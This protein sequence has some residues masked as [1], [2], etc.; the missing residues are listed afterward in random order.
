MSH[1]YKWDGTDDIASVF[2]YSHQLG[3]RD[4]SQTP[5][6]LLQLTFDE[7]QNLI[8]IQ[9]AYHPSMNLTGDEMISSHEKQQEELQ[10]FQTHL[11]QKIDSFLH[12]LPSSCSSHEQKWFVKTNRHSCKDSPLDHPTEK[13]LLIYSHELD[14]YP[15]PPQRNLDEIDFGSAF[16]AMC[17]S[18]LIS[19]AIQNGTD[20]I[21]LLLRSKRI[22]D[23]FTLQIRLCPSPWD[24]YL[25]FT[26]F[27]DHMAQYPLHE[28]RCYI[29]NR[30]LRCIM[31]YSYLITCPIPSADLLHAVQAISDYL[32]EHFLPSLSSDILDLAVDLQCIPRDHNPTEFEIKFIETNPLGPGTVWGHLHWET[33]QPWLL[34]PDG[35]GHNTSLLPPTGRICDTQGG[36]RTVLWIPSP[37][38]SFGG[39]GGRDEDRC[40]CVV[41]YTSRHPV[42][43][44]WGGLAHIP[45]DYMLLIW[46]KWKL[47]ELQQVDQ[48]QGGEGIEEA[49]AEQKSLC[50]IG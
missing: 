32:H 8:Q 7:V 16:L 36:E 1:Q 10:T 23:D 12:T 28:F 20:V 50:V 27:D 30:Q 37:G 13:D 4:T 34:F 48:D 5:T 9:S 18:R 46:E 14:Q 38:Q 19:T 39:S 43:M 45:P 29:S 44:V 40:V 31:Q 47:Q 42:G 21:N 6:Y 11:I 35:E 15:I 3:P 17:R 26:P 49:E 24:C 25:A 22:Y 2:Q 33:D 41:M